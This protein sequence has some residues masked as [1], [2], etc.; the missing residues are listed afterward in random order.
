[1]STF[2]TNGILFDLDGTLWDSTSE[3]ADAWNEL[4]KIKVAWTDRL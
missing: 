2:K 3:I 4:I 1:M